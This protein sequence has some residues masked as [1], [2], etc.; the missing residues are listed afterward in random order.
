MS[1]DLCS[2]SAR[3]SAL[4]SDQRV[5]FSSH[6]TTESFI[7]CSQH[8]SLTFLQTPGML[9]CAFSQ[10]SL[11]TGHSLKKLRY[12]CRSD[13][14]SHLSQGTL[15]FCQSGHW[16]VGHSLTKVL[17]SWLLSLIRWPAQGR[18]W[19]I[20]FSL[21]FLMVEFTVLL[22]TLNTINGFIHFPR[23]MPPQN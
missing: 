13:R 5:Q 18:V 4:H 19:V 8:L 20:P 10:D 2:V 23:S 21:H 15:Q 14:F 7:S 3:C 17:P 12:C 1:G 11:P 16:L 6:Q 22:G 9:S